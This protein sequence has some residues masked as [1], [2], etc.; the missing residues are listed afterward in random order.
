MMSDDTVGT[1][2]HCL[3][4]GDSDGFFDAASFRILPGFDGD[5]AHFQ[6]CG[7][8]QLFTMAGWVE[9]RGNQLMW[10]YHQGQTRLPDPFLLATF[11]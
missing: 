10:S 4:S 6:E 5:T 9:G 8:R 2:G 1:A 7:A 11:A 3:R